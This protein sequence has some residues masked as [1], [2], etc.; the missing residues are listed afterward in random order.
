MSVPSDS[1]FAPGPDLAPVL[2]ALLRREGIGLLEQ[3]ARL[4]GLLRDYAPTAIRDIRLLL[5]AHDAG[6]PRRLEAAA[7][8]VAAEALSAEA[9]RMV[10]EFG[11]ARPLAVG[12]VNTWARALAGLRNAPSGSGE[13]PSPLL[14][15][16]GAAAGPRPV[17]D[18]APSPIGRWGG[19][20]LAVLLVLVALARWLGWT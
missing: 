18:D 13:V 8:P 9:D 20:A 15:S 11:C 16:P 5:A 1:Q 6:T 2:L 19:I 3:R 17:V 7:D 14:P 12:A 4:N 10:E